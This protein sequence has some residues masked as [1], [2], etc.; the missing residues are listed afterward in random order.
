MKT[1]IKV[2]GT[3]GSKGEL[4]LGNANQDELGQFVTS[5]YPNLLT[6]AKEYLF[7]WKDEQVAKGYTED[8]LEGIIRFKTYGTDVLSIS[9]SPVLK[10]PHAYKKGNTI[11]GV[12]FHF[13]SPEYDKA[14]NE[15]GQKLYDQVMAPV[16]EKKMAKKQEAMSKLIAFANN[17]EAHIGWNCNVMPDEPGN[18]SGHIK[19]LIKE[20]AELL[21]PEIEE[22]VWAENERRKQLKVEQDARKQEEKEQKEKAYK[23]GK[24]SLENWAKEHGSDLLKLRIQH[25]Q[26]WLEMAEKEYAISIL[27]EGWEDG[28]DHKDSYE[29]KNGSLNLLKKLSELKKQYPGIYFTPYRYTFDDYDEYGFSEFENYKQDWISASVPTLYG[30][31]TLEIF[32]EDYPADED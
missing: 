24:A 19:S 32:F 30:Y 17:E 28:P 22:R 25:D 1:I 29:I 15:L 9:A 12:Q 16:K 7:K 18:F 31:Y 6:Q 14:T 20:A 10:T 27:G 5:A 2:S 26:N 3:V 13:T 11:G 21:T 23:E 4:D 8:E